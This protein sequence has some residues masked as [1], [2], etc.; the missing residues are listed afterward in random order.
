MDGGQW[1]DA[2]DIGNMY[3]RGEGV[4]KDCAKACELHRRPVDGGHVDAVNSLGD[5]YVLGEGVTQDS[6]R[7]AALYG[8]VATNS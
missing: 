6:A 1:D 4:A 3:T 8:R 2:F 7:A 5:M